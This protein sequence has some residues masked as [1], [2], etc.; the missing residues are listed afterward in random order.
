[1]A[2]LEVVLRVCITLPLRAPTFVKWKEILSRSLPLTFP[3][4]ATHRL[5]LYPRLTVS[6]AVTTRSHRLLAVWCLDRYSRD[7]PKNGLPGHF[8]TLAVTPEV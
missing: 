2:R 8:R 4:S 5:A 6:P 7:R 3:Y 1:M